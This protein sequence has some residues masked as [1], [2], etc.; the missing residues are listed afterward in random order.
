VAYVCGAFPIF[1][2]DINDYRLKIAEKMG[3][4]IIVLNPERDDVEGTI[5][6]HTRGYGA[7][8]VIE[9]AGSTD[10]TRTGFK[11][12]RK[13]GRICIIGLHSS[14]V[15]L[16]FVNNVTYKEATVYGITGREMFDSWYLA[17]NLLRSGRINVRDVLTHS[18]PLEKTAQAILTA[19]EGNCGKPVIT[20]AG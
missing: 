5:R 19:Q 14:E 3:E 16:D 18:F 12:L 13:D 8:V 20:I 4:G 2:I 17:E 1:A 6:E 9:L 11:S 7:D 10:A 15:S